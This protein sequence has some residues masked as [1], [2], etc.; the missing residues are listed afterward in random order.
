[1]VQIFNL[2]VEMSFVLSLEIIKIKV[3]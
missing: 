2:F 1:M 3:K